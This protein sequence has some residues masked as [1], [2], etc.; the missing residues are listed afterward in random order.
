MPALTTELLRQLSS[1]LIPRNEMLTLLR[2]VVDDFYGDSLDT[3]W[4]TVVSGSGIAAVLQDGSPSNILL[5]TGTTI[6]STSELTEGGF[7]K[8]N[9]TDRLTVR[10]ISRIN[11]I[12]T[13]FHMPI[14][15]QNSA[16]TNR[17]SI[18]YNTS[19][20]D[21]GWRL[22][23]AAPGFTSSAV[24]LAADV[25]WHTF[26]LAIQS[27]SVKARIDGGA[28]VENTS[29][30]PLDNLQLRLLIA[31]SAAVSR[32]AQWDLVMLLPGRALF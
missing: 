29:N 13:V 2:A 10:A 6:N 4:N 30:I 22:R 1:L 27:G 7:E 32:T 17:I 14:N 8:W 15:L 11:A 16:L 20:G 5:E 26:D 23:T 19:T 21:T 3:R 31:N 18:D 24:I 25:L 12:T 28:V 9:V